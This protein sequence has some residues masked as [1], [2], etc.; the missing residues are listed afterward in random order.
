MIVPAPG[1]S[2]ITTKLFLM[3]GFTLTGLI[4]VM[5]WLLNRAEMRHYVAMKV[6][7]SHLISE[8]ILHNMT[9]YMQGREMNR[10]RETVNLLVAEQTDIE[11][12]RLINRYGE[13]VISSDG[14]EAGKVLEKSSSFCKQCHSRE[15]PATAAPKEALGAVTAGPSWRK[16]ISVATPIYNDVSCFTAPCHVHSEDQNV[17]GMI[18]TDYSLAGMERDVMMRQRGV[19]AA[20]ALAVAMTFVVLWVFIARYVTIPVRGLLRGMRSV[21]EGDLAYRY[22]VTVEDEIGHIGTVF[23]RMMDELAAKTGELRMTGDR[24]EGIIESS[25]DIITT[26][27]SDGIIES[28]NAAGERTLGY[29]RSEVV[30]QRVEML[31]ENPSDREAAVRKLAA[32]DGVVNYETRF[33]RRDGAPVDVMLTMSRLRDPDGKQLGTICISKDVTA[34]RELQQKVI[35]SERLA[36]IGTAL[37][38][39]SHNAK[40]ILNNLKGGAYMIRLGFSKEKMSLLREGW[41]VVE[42]GI[43][44]LSAM[45]MDMLNFTRTQKL[46]FREASLNEIVGEVCDLLMMSARDSKVDITWDLD[47]YLPHVTADAEAIH[48]AVLNLASNAVESCGYKDYPPGET[49]FVHIRTYADAGKEYAAVEVRDNGEGIGDDIKDRVFEPFFTTKIEK[50]TGLGLAIT[51]RAVSDHG[52]FIELDSKEGEG[53]SF[54]IRLPIGGKKEGG[55]K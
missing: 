35:Q 3:L 45:A 54:T 18:Q 22:P 40:N 23:N 25:G 49:P 41:S 12:I 14:G 52:G 50:G 8:V 19:L 2:R 51:A 6:E 53:T 10:I 21:A 24:L 17:L 30:G 32:G 15:T 43:S 48:T 39:I 38:G 5:G 37:A 20:A 36:A 11:R 31:F 26:V 9:R 28:M 1:K 29:D 46:N 47:P 34:Y 27:N 4:A 55:A 44:K 33:R 13:I 42:M 16:F 7:N